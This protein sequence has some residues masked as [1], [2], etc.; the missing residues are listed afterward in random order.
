ME[1]NDQIAGLIRSEISGYN[2]DLPISAANIA[3]GVYVRIDSERV[4]P[5][6]VQYCTILNLR[7]RA[8]KELAREFDK[9][10]DDSTQETLFTGLQD[11]YP[12]TR[13][14]Q[15]VYV[16]RLQMTENEYMENASRLE[17]EGRTKIE[18]ADALRVE[19]AKLFSA[20]VGA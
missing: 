19:A 7:E 12:A 3:S 6:L 5:V 20:S 13:N 1:Q 17:R 14:G 18:H 9:G 4:S 15:R 11:R 10:D 8:R 16:P 2:C